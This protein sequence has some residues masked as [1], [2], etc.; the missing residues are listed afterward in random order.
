MQISL[1]NYTH[2]R[3]HIYRHISVNILLIY[4]LI[5][6]TPSKKYI[7][8]RFVDLLVIYKG[9]RNYRWFFL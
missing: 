8:Y 6:M 5:S 4:S 1:K 3:V 9:S 7:L 2:I